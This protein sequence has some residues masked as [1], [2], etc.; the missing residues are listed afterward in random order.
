MPWSLQAAAEQDAVVM[1]T[2]KAVHAIL[3]VTSTNRVFKGLSK[4]WKRHTEN[5]PLRSQLNELDLDCTMT[6]VEVLEHL[7]SAKISWTDIDGNVHPRKRNVFSLLARR[8]RC[9]ECRAC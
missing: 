8:R 2:V 1:F 6:D 9:H 5:D 4:A 7:A 3:Q